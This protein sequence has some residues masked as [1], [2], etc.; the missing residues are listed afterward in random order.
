MTVWANL[1][2]ARDGKHL[3]VAEFWKNGRVQDKAERSLVVSDPLKIHG[4]FKSVESNTA[5]TITVVEPNLSGSLIIADLILSTE[6]QNGGTVTIQFTDGTD[7]ALIYK[8]FATDAPVSIS[9]G[10]S[11]RLQGWKD[12]RIELVNVGDTD[13]TLLVTYVKVPDAFPF[14]QW[15]ELR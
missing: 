4:T 3:E 11:G 13:C 5:E 6:R 2:D 1:K 15:D 9:T 10:I 7:T 14:A 12:A 8:V